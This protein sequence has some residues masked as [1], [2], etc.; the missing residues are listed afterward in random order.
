MAKLNQIIA[1]TQG[2]KTK[3]Q[4]V[5]TELYKRLQN[6]DLFNGLTKTYEPVDDEGEKLPTEKKLNQLNVPD[7]IKEARGVFGELIDTI[8]TQ[9]SA[10]CEAKADVVV[11]GKVVAT[12]VPVTH[13]LYLEK[14]LVDL[15]TFVSKLPILD[16]SFEWELDDNTGTYRTAPMTTI[17]NKRVFKNHVKAEATEKH[18]AQVDTYQED[19]RVGEFKTTK[20]SGAVPSKS[21]KE[22]LTRVDK[23]VD[24]VKVAREQAN[25]AEV[26]S[27]KIADGLL[28]F[29]FEA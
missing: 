28:S 18:P 16:A 15:R 2:K 27:K 25:N 24:A 21:R 26:V 19:V 29:V 9:D 4:A 20:L 6:E 3:T 8:Y 17:R 14:Q 13:L 22:M 1:V 11:D 7:V 5:M 12:E 23:L 10:N